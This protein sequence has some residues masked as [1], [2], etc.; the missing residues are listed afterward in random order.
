VF[1]GNYLAVAHGQRLALFEVTG[2]R[3]CSAGDGDAPA[4]VAALAVSPHMPWVVGRDADHRHV[5]WW[6]PGGDTRVLARHTGARDHAIGSFVEIAD[7]SFI[8]LSQGGRLRLLR[9]DGSEAAAL[10]IDRPVSF[11]C[12][13]FVQLPG[14][15]VAIVGNIA[16][17]PTDMVLVVSARALLAGPDAVQRALAATR[18]VDG[19]LVHDRAIALIVGPGPGETMVA[20]RDPEDEEPPPDADDDAAEYPDVWGLR[21]TYLRDLTSRALVER[22]A[23]DVQFAKLAAVCATARVIAVETR[24]GVDVR[25]RATCAVNHLAG[26]V[27]DPLGSRLAIPADGGWRLHPLPG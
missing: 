7:E 13:G 4:D 10:A 15:R 6:R 3:L 22:A 18:V 8:A 20:L 24:G 26:A 14:G 5:W 12:H 19:P 9:G 17:E 11:A 27:L 2:D 16:G 21:G 23:W 25:D 1:R